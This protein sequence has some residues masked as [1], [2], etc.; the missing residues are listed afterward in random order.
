MASAN[1]LFRLVHDGE[2]Y[3]FFA[4]RRE[5]RRLGS[6]F[7][8]G[9][10]AEVLLAALERWGVGALKRLRGMF[11]F[12]LYDARD[13]SV[14]LARDRFGVKPLYYSRDALR[15]CAASTIRAVLASGVE[16]QADPEAVGSYLAFGSVCA[17]R[18]IARD[19]WELPPGHWLRF[20]GG[21]VETGSYWT[22]PGPL[23]R[24]PDEKEAVREVERLVK[25]AVR[26][27][28][29]AD[30][31][32]G[33]LLSSGM[34]SSAVAACAKEER[35]LDAFTVGFGEFGPGL[36]EIASASAWAEKLGV[37]HHALRLS[38]D[39]CLGALPEAF[40]AMDQPSI[41]AASAWVVSLAAKSAGVGVALSG[42]GGDELFGGYPHLRTAHER[43]SWYG[44]LGTFAPAAR[45][46]GAAMSPLARRSRRLG[47]AAS[48]LASGGDPVRLYAARRALF[49]LE[50]SDGILAPELAARWRELGNHGFVV[51]DDQPGAEPAWAQTEI[52]F[53][54]WLPNALLRDADAMSMRHGLELRLPLLDHDL[55]E[56]VLS[57]PLAYR[58]KPGLQKPLLAA[59]VPA[60]PKA[61]PERRNGFALP[62]ARWLRGPLRGAVQARLSRLH[63]AG[64]FVTVEGVARLWDRFLTGED[65]V[66]RRIWSIHVL[67]RWLEKHR[68][69]SWARR[70]AGSTGSGMTPLPM[71]KAL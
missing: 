30:A 45:A 52:E 38:A 43:A 21:R 13:G 8:S 25:N 29:A 62:Y 20:A 49:V 32:L 63:F 31:P 40:D 7:R 66:W 61:G 59:A 17:P 22:L 67:D 18:T 10:D 3:N 26:S 1:G 54:N 33:A 48:L 55:V 16:F 71:Q 37:R 56:Y 4:L 14:L 36:D 42:L 35:E 41:D 46:A 24:P 23:A 39:A 5:L 12:A 2:I 34:D 50:R 53:R 15:L 69:A 57:L 51:W 27:Q 60:L 9:S 70:G 28:L 44:A 58:F 68:F 11:A 65:R 64:E 47:K 6:S 19:V